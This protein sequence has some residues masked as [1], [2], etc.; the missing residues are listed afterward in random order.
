[1]KPP[2]E[3]KKHMVTVPSLLESLHRA[4]GT[5][6][7]DGGDLLVRFAATPPADLVEA[8]RR[9]KPLIVAFLRGETV[10]Y[11]QGPDEGDLPGDGSVPADGSAP[12]DGSGH[13]AG[14]DR[15]IETTSP[16]A[17][18]AATLPDALAGD[19]VMPP[20]LGDAMVR[21]LDGL[22]RERC[23][24]DALPDGQTF[25]SDCPSCRMAGALDLSEGT[26][27]LPV[28]RS[29]CRCL[30]PLLALEGLEAVSLA[31]FR[32]PKAAAFPRKPKPRKPDAVCPCGSTQWRDVPIHGGRSIRRDCAR[33]GRFL[34]FPLW[35]GQ[36]EGDDQARAPSGS[37][38][39]PSQPTPTYWPSWAQA[40]H[41]KLVRAGCHPKIVVARGNGGRPTSAVEAT[42]PGCTWPGGLVAWPLTIGTMH[43]HCRA[44][45]RPAE[46]FAGLD[47]R[48][49]QRS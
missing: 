24:V 29:R 16:S 25:R 9:H 38:P 32:Q 19:D 39:D 18:A 12:A 41:D 5:V 1:L 2:V 22:H 13:A 23:M 28:I 43:A 6:R 4:G 40:F 27:G 8:I 36:P 34:G 45:C 37:Q 10:C 42:C 7:L 35:Y 44:G 14:D 17:D 46:V 33:C 49:K 15:A 31:E 26:D 30:D 48:L 3:R 21:L 20:P 11:G 47:K